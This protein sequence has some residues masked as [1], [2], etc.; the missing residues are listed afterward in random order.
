MVE[1]EPAARL[2]AIEQELKK[3]QKKSWFE[4][5]VIPLAIAI[6][7]G[8][9]TV[10]IT[11]AQVQSA[12]NI[13]KS[14]QEQT[15]RLADSNLQVVKEKS[16]AEQRLKALEL[17]IKYLTDSKPEV[18]ESGVKLLEV[19]EPD[20][21]SKLRATL[22]ISD[23]SA[24][25]RRVAAEARIAGWFAVVYSIA[26][27]EEAI[28]KAQSLKGLS[29]QPEVYKATDDRG[30]VVYAV[31]LGGYLSEEE[32]RSRAAYGRAKVSSDAYAWQSAK[33]GKDLLVR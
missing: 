23:P 32:A 4:I 15:S 26:N 27:Q 7:G 33:W 28:Q 18:R 5:A 25:V 3:L 6:T 19:I 21:A 29:Y 13:A 2:S 11:R 17:C 31:T 8:V 12:E 1:D 24:D 22:L 30:N 16:A 20:L 9:G 14:N 10:A